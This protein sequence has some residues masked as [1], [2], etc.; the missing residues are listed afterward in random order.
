MPDTEVSPYLRDRQRA[1][2]AV[3]MR[4]R[5]L[6]TWRKI[7]AELGY[8]DPGS[9]RRAVKRVLHALPDADEARFDLYHH[10]DGLLLSVMKKA[11]DGSAPHARV[12]VQ[13]AARMSALVGSDAPTKAVHDVTV[14]QGESTASRPEY[15]GM[16]L[17]EWIR[18]GNEPTDTDR[19]LYG[20]TPKVIDGMREVKVIDQ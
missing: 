7:A 11:R 14:R 8:A 6:W 10:L 5:K 9:A 12:A 2:D 20:L 3:E 18:A 4:Y 19:L 16:S 15:D 17:L 13:I 1:H